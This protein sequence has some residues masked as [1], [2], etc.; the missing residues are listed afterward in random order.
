MCF[1]L[2]VNVQIIKLLVPHSLPHPPSFSTSSFSSP[3]PSPPPSPHLHPSHHL[4][5]SSHQHHTLLQIHFSQ[6]SPITSSSSPPP[7]PPP[8]PINPQST[9]LNH[10]F[11][12][13]PHL[14]LPSSLTLLLPHPPPTPP[15]RSL[16][17]WSMSLFI[18][19]LLPE[20]CECSN[21]LQPLMCFWT[22]EKRARRR[23][24]NHASLLRCF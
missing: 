22:V 7:P 20:D 1:V 16:S 17:P 5:T 6:T 10:S 24:C 9:L 15:S 4:L 14:P 12:Y 23:W 8:P 21:A 2:V 13:P 19:T 18:G 11:H 3:P